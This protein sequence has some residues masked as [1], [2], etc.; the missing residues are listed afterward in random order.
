MIVTRKV[1][2]LCIAMYGQTV[3]ASGDTSLPRTSISRVL[4]DVWT[5]VTV[6]GLNS[7]QLR[8]K[9]V[10]GF[11]KYK[12]TSPLSSST[13][14]NANI[15]CCHSRVSSSIN[16]RANTREGSSGEVFSLLLSP[17]ATPSP[18]G[19]RKTASGD[20]PRDSDWSASWS[21]PPPFLPGDLEAS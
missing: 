12:R 2:V 18:P 19:T 4:D 21:F 11:G 5:T 10:R 9:T 8:G 13:P 15:R 7:H 1:S 17:S 20:A 6:I 3:R 14:A 16:C